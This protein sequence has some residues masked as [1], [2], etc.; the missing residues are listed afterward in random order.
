MAKFKIGIQVVE[1]Y[2]KYLI[3]DADSE[4]EAVEKVEKVWEQDSDYLYSAV[5]GCCDSQEVNFFKY[6]KA[7]ESDIM[8]LD[9]LGRYDDEED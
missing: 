2:N 8:I 7:S 4:K 9:N 3:V 6:G 1:T 5:T